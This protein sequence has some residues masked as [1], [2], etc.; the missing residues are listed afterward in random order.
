MQEGSFV[1]LWG[2]LLTAALEQPLARHEWSMMTAGQIA[3][4]MSR[5]ALPCAI[6]SRSAGDTGRASRN[7]RARALEAKGYSA[8]NMMRSAPNFMSAAKKGAIVKNPLVVIQT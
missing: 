3:R 8:E 7:A 2:D 5:S 4:F 6:F 1:A